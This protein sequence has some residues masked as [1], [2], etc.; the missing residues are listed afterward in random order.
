MSKPGSFHWKNRRLI[1]AVI[2]IFVCSTCLCSCAKDNVSNENQKSLNEQP[3][4]MIEE[5]AEESISVHF[6]DIG[7]ADCIL[8]K[9]GDK[10]VLIDSGTSEKANDIV[11]YLKQQGVTKL[12]YAVATHC[13]KDHVGGMSAVLNEFPTDV[14]LMSSRGK[15]TKPYKAMIDTAVQLEV[16][17]FIPKVN[18]VFYVDGVKFTV[19]APGDKAMAAKTDNESSIVLMMQY[20]EKKFLFMGDAMEVS[21][22]EMLSSD[23]NLHADV[24]KVGHHGSKK[25]SSEEF[26]DTVNPAVAVITCEE[27][28]GT[29]LP[30]KKTLEVISQQHIMLYRTDRDGTIIM[31]TN[32]I[33]IKIEK[34]NKN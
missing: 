8:V 4:L 15:S 9:I 29:S 31:T 14:L 30:E 17:Q 7:K 2:M 34:S 28:D 10:A 24:I 16:T 22:K 21:E 18:T 33:D 11:A 6:L 1:V 19:L 20:G 13:D 25:C 12:E 23:Y 26:L 27:G 32:G 3:E 5:E